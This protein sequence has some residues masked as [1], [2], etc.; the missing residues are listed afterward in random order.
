MNKVDKL[1]REIEQLELDEQQELFNRLE[2]ILD[3]LGWIKLNEVKL[4]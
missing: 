4:M 3:M 1:V 2:D